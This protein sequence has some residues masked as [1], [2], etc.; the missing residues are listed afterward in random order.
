[1]YL[2]LIWVKSTNEG[3]LVYILKQIVLEMQFFEILILNKIKDNIA[4]S[5][6]I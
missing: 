5:L 6:S 4:R 3:D 2:D 1:M